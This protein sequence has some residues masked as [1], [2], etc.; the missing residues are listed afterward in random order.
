MIVLEYEGKLYEVPDDYVVI[1]RRGNDLVGLPA[2]E[3]EGDDIFHMTMSP[4]VNL[5]RGESSNK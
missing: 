4:A 5:I 1:A 3:A 2:S